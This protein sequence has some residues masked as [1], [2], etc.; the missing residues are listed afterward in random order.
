MKILLLLTLISCQSEKP[1]VE[2]A[3]VEFG[4]TYANEM[5]FY[6]QISAGEEAYLAVETG[7]K[8]DQV[9]V[10]NGTKVRQGDI[11]MILDK[12]QRSSRLKEAISDFKLA[13]TDYNRLRRLFRSGASSKQELDSATNRYEVQ[14][15][16]LATAKKHLEDAVVK[17]PFDG[18]VAAITFKT[19]E[20]VHNGGR[21][22]VIERT[23]A[24]ELLTKVKSSDAP[25]LP[26]LA[27]VEIAS[28]NPSTRQILGDRVVLKTQIEVLNLDNPY[29][30]AYKDVKMTWD[31][32]DESLR[33]GRMVAVKVVVNRYEDLSEIPAEAIIN[34]DD[35]DYV[36]VGST[37]IAPSLLP[38]EVIHISGD[39]VLIKKIPIKQVYT[40]K[41]G[42]DWKKY[43]SKL[44]VYQNGDR[45]EKL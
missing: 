30:A 5:I 18:V 39:R 3:K 35:K 20:L 19:G 32:Q 42:D 6:G 26:K 11:I 25:L 29:D 43:V 17:A 9:L 38:V 8:V 21:V 34:R 13:K 27:D 23:G 33:S 31:S 16:K 14:K 40:P 37:S 45:K 15:A 10:K 36:A 24:F 7:G 22:A 41:R 28:F 2:L 4:K 12:V 44:N 1:P